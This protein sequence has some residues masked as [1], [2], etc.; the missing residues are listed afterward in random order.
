M[1]TGI[2]FDIK[3]FAV[4]DGPG[5]RTTVFLK[6]CP[7]R[8]Q[9]C[10][11]PEG[12]LMRPQLLVSAAACTHCGA[13]AKV[14]RHDPCAAC[15][16]CVPLC[17]MG[18]RRIAGR[19]WRSAQLAARLYKDKAFLSENGGGVTFSG[20]EP[21]S[22]WA[23]ISD[24]IDQMPGLHTAIET[25]GHCPDDVFHGAMRKA[26]LILMDI[27]H[28]DPGKHTHFT[29]ADNASILAHA[30][31]LRDGDTDF[32]LRL[33][34]I[35]GVNDD[36][37]HIEDIAGFIEGAERLI[38]VE[39]LP[40]HRTAGAKYEM[41]GMIYSPEFDAAREPRACTEPFLKRGIEVMVL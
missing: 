25:S 41:A 40:Y 22:Q 24:V 3:E 26:N 7:L 27:K 37:K 35:P 38:R 12:L 33:P 14:C 28:M 1:T 19:E 32:I 34:L 9:W 21:L 18:L 10:H 8:C 39:M 36:E 16:A 30:Q 31:M 4:Y 13:C 15:G 2:V 17:R 11:N 6:G 29:G 20:G 23:F 5:V